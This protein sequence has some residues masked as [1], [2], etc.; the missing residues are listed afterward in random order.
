MGV[1]SEGDEGLS[2]SND[3]DDEA[4]AEAEEGEEEELELGVNSGNT[5]VDAVVGSRANTPTVLVADSLEIVASEQVD[6]PEIPAFVTKQ[7]TKGRYIL[8]HQQQMQQKLQL[9][10]EVQQLTW[11]LFS[12]LCCKLFRVIVLLVLDVYASIQ[13]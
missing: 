9:T 12:Q 1:N 6:I 11:L 3:D 8:P 4:K 13:A 7:F 2:V 10:L 5:G